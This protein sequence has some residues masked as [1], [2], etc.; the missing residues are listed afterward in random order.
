MTAVAAAVAA[1]VAAA[2]AAAAAAAGVV[3]SCVVLRHVVL[4]ALC[5]VQTIIPDLVPYHTSTLK[6]VS[7]F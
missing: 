3:V 1:S 6:S 4:S 5:A 7:N 2:A